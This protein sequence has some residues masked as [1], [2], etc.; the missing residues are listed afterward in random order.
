MP[1]IR[2]Q[3]SRNFDTAWDAA[4]RPWLGEVAKLGWTQTR[5]VALLVPTRAHA[6]A[7]RQ[8]LHR[9]RISIAALRIW[10]PATS[11]DHLA[12]TAQI[13]PGAAIRENLHLLLSHTAA[14]L[15]KSPTARAISRDSS[16]LMRSLDTLAAG[17]HLTPTGLKHLPDDAHALADK[18]FQR[19]EKLGWRTVQQL[20]KM[21]L[22]QA[23][24]DSAVAPLRALLAVGFDGSHWEVRNLLHALA[25]SADEAL[26]VF[27]QPR[28][29]AEQ[30]DQLWIGSW[31]RDTQ[32]EAEVLPDADVPLPYAPLA[33]RMENTGVETRDDV[34]PAEILIGRNLTEQAT[35]IAARVALWLAD[36]DDTKIGILVPAAGPLAREISLRLLERGIV[37]HDTIGHPDAPDRDAQ[38]FTA[39]LALQRDQT[40]APLLA[41]LEFILPASRSELRDSLEKA[42]TELFTDDLAVLIAWLREHTKSAHRNAAELLRGI[43][44]LPAQSTLRDFIEATQRV[45]EPLGWNAVRARLLQQTQPVEGLLDESISR[46]LFLDWLTVITTDLP[47]RRDP[48][49]T[50]PASPV[51][52]IACSSAEGLPW[53]HLLLAGL[54]ENQWPPSFEPQGY[55][56]EA[57]IATL[58]D[59]VKSTG[60]RGEGDFVVKENHALILGPAEQRALAR[61]QFYNLVEVPTFGLTLTAALEDDESARGLG[62]SDFLSHLYFTQ[63]G[64]P[65]TEQVLAELHDATQRW[66]AIGDVPPTFLS[67]PSIEQTRIANEARNAKGVPFGPYE[68]ALSNPPP[69]QLA[70]RCTALE[71][72]IA[73]P[74]AVWL[75]TVLGVK[76]DSDLL[77]GDT[78]PLATGTWVHAWLS[79]AIAAN[80]PEKLVP[81]SDAAQFAARTHAAAQLTREMAARAFTAAQR[82]LPDHWQSGWARAAWIAGELATHVGSVADWPYAATEWKLPNPT[83]IHAGPSKLLVRGR[84]DLVLARDENFTNGSP[85]WLFDFK[86]GSNKPLKP[87]DLL[88]KFARDGKGLQ[89]A[90]YALALRSLGASV[91]AIT[92]LTPDTEV[93]PQL[94]STD[95]ESLTNF[96][97]GIARMQTTGIFGMRRSANEGY[98]FS[99]QMPLTTR[100]PSYDLLE[101]KWSLTHPL[102]SAEEEP[103]KT[104][105]AQKENEA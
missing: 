30:I 74:A 9:E 53:T 105:E 75:A 89:L 44:L 41:V 50:N 96:W 97:R 34:R 91:V 58:N 76:A 46:G 69:E 80:D 43:A 42:C 70:M 103:Q 27:N 17:G 5:P 51:Q 60:P 33:A 52:I 12:A 55:L 72:S 16:R 65:L 6:T 66:T 36:N 59:S 21:L 104:E 62:P 49:T 39:W 26:L 45:L 85:L 11:R 4:V 19:L 25:V 48:R 98:S 1:K 82:A 2:I 28:Y 10:T 24:K 40:L 23:Q 8:R 54:N 81:I 3:L 38:G 102:L 73:S 56:R 100:L 79:N 93:A 92:L 88:K 18:F 31:E 13:P 68:F 90:L 15:E 94:T 86:T 35:A 14:Q 32:S 61:R 29:K 84:V 63:T 77:D 95:I 101:E 99:A 64:K 71:Q 7:L 83:T 57:D 37:H 78:L 47:T 87:K 22:D 67:T 20:D